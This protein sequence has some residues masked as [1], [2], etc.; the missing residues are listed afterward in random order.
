MVYGR[1]SGLTGASRQ[2][3]GKGGRE[4]GSKAGRRVGGEAENHKIV[5]AV[6]GKSLFMRQALFKDALQ[7]GAC[8]SN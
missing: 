4:S 3:Q 1:G 8:Q 7:A 5:S 2:Q 6:E